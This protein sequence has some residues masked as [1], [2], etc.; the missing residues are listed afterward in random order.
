MGKLPKDKISLSI[1]VSSDAKDKLLC[2]QQIYF[3]SGKRFSI[4][5]IV[6]DSIEVNYAGVYLLQE[7]GFWRNLFMLNK[8]I[9]FGARGKGF[10]SILKIVESKKAA[11]KEILNIPLVKSKDFKSVVKALWK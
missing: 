5:Q 6:Q 11:M 9:N 2:L 7:G 1:Y 4:S 3:L 8:F 10:D